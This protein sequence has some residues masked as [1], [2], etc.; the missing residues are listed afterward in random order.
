MTLLISIALAVLTATT[1]P[2][3]TPSNDGMYLDHGVIK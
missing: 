1:T 3:K 2:T